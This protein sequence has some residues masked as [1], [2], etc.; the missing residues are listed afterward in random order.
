MKRSR[1]GLAVLIVGSGQAARCH[2]GLL[3][4]HHP[5]VSRLY[6]GRSPSPTRALAARFG[7]R[8]IEGSWDRAVRD[9]RVDA[10]FITTP[11]D[12][13]RDMAV[14][15]LEAG[16]HVIVE[17]PAFLTGAEFDA[18]EAA[19]T[20]SGRQ[21]LVAENYNYKPLLRAIRREIASGVLG[22]VRLILIDAVKRQVADGWRADPARAGGGALFESG[23]HWVSFMDHL[24]LS[25]R[26]ARA[27]FPDAPGGMERSAVFV[28]EYDEGAVGVLSHSWEIPG[29]LR[30]LRLSRVYGTRGSLLF[31]SNGLFLLRGHRRLSFP[32]L[33]DIQGY[34][35][36]L[37]DFIKV[38]RTGTEPEYTIAD[39][40]RCVEL[41]QDT[42][43]TYAED[44]P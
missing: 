9:E 26:R 10:V 43:N 38:L 29:L 13:H 41:I 27:W 30:G 36:M 6:W 35:A 22:Q 20:R 21:V 12:T 7:G 39:A 42:Y 15:A 1:R 34:R 32:G 17:K 18:V 4:R 31:E 8:R 33:S 3:A 25:M 44:S 2:A 14:A 40:R 16:K 23:I 28:A 5:G 37:A 24:G 19:A 11:P